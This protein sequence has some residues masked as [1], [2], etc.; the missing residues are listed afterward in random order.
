[1]DR[2]FETAGYTADALKL[3]VEGVDFAREDL[4][5]EEQKTRNF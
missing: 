3:A 2:L 5:G 4:I 1:M